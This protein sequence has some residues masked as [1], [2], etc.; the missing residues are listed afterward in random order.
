MKTFVK[1]SDLSKPNCH[2]CKEPLRRDLAR[3]KEWCVN[4]SCQVH[5][6]QF[7]ISYV[8]DEIDA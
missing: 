1:R 7:N 5:R 4:S 2:V 8:Y 3:E 6:I